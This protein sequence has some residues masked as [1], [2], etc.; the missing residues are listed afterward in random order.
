MV[1]SGHL[2]LGV[3]ILVNHDLSLR[4]DKVMTRQVQQKTAP[5]RL[6]PPPNGSNPSSLRL[7]PS[8]GGAQFAE[9]FDRSHPKFHGGNPTVRHVS[10]RPDR[11]P[12]RR[13]EPVMLQ[14]DPS[15]GPWTE[16]VKGCARGAAAKGGGGSSLGG[17]LG[18][19]WGEGYKV[20]TLET[21]WNRLESPI[22]VGRT[23]SREPW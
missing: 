22:F 11:H 6:P 14:S 8:S 21:C 23:S 15:N 20:K 12:V 1:V 10:T 13:V 2:F 3:I 18:L 16:G 9:Q 19:L 17:L 5:Q 4:S 7:A